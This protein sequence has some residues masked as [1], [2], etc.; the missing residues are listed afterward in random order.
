MSR[1]IVL[2]GTAGYHPSEQRQTSCLMIPELGIVLDAGTG[3]HRAT[4]LLQTDTL[5]IFLSHAHLDHVIGLTYLFDIVLRRTMQRVAVHGEA[6]KLE[7]IQSHMLDFSLF[8]ANLPCS[9]SPITGP[10]PLRGG[11][12]LT[13]FP[14]KHPGGSVG[15]RLDFGDGSMAYVTDTTASAT[16]DYVEKIRGVDLLIHECNFPDGWETWAEKTGHSC[17]TPVCEVA[18]AAEVKQ[19]VLVHH[20]PLADQPAIAKEFSLALDLEHARSIFPAVVV[21]NDWDKFTF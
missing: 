10:V 15:M 20:N 12:T 18:R 11:G 7:S 4:S 3:I 2:L 8:P 16:A 21:G 14:L 13:T 1:T 19:L 5:D 17:L 9:W 6:A